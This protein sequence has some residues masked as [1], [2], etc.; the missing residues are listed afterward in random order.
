MTAFD[1]SVTVPAICA[2]CPNAEK[3]GCENNRKTDNRRRRFDRE[4]MSAAMRQPFLR[5]G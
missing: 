4:M 3:N 5:P 1:G 2:F